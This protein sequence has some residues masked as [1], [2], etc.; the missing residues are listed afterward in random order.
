MRLHCQYNIHLNSIA[1]GIKNTISMRNMLAFCMTFVSISAYAEQQ[2]DHVQSVTVNGVEVTRPITYKQLTKLFHGKVPAIKSVI[3]SWC[4]ANYD[5]SMDVSN[6]VTGLE[7]VQE[8]NPRWNLDQLFKVR[9]PNISASGLK[10]K[11]WLA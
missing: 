7:Y 8:I 5:V 6:P 9:Q 10:A 4:T 11:V 2:Y 1:F 3:F